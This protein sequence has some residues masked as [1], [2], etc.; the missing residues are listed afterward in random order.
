MPSLIDLHI[1]SQFSDGQ[2]DIKDLVE[3]SKKNNVDL[4]SITDHDDIRSVFELKN[5]PNISG[6]EYIN[7]V[8][9]S[10]I[11]KLNGRNIILHILGYGYD[12]K[13]EELISRLLEK[14]KLRAIVNKKYLVNLIHEF[15]YLSYDILENIQYDKYVRLSRL[16]EATLNN[17][18]MSNDQLNAIKKYLNSN[19]PIYP[20]YEFDALES[21]QIIRNAN[22]YP[23]LA[24]PYQYRLNVKEEIALLKLLKENGLIGLEKYHSGDT[25][26]GMLLQE[27]M[28]N[29]FNLEWTLGSDF[30][31]DHDDFGNQIGYGKNKNLC[32]S[33][34]SLIK[35]LRRNGKVLKR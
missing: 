13:N 4:I 35:T 32:R 33:S 10:S 19:R 17:E 7:G 3:L 31:E 25:P 5:N 28:C 23:V 21:L 1:H 12:E 34:C 27:M 2:F 16:I 24:H 22:G 18:E 15:P 14:K 29:K 30:H 26:I 9:L 6:I 20:D 8:E 11:V